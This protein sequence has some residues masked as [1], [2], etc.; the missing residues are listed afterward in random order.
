MITFMKEIYFIPP[1]VYLLLFVIF[2][3]TNSMAKAHKK[4]LVKN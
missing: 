4:K 1:I 3:T 2:H